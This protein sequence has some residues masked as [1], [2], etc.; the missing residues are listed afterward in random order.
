M[1]KKW[2]KEDEEKLIEL[3]GCNL[4]I[5]EIAEVLNRSKKAIY[6]RISLLGLSKKVDY[7]S[8][9]EIAKLE[10]M[11][12]CGKTPEI[13]SKELGRTVSAIHAK[14]SD[15]GLSKDRSWTKQ[16]DE[17]L[18]KY[19]ANNI[20][21][22]KIAELLNRTKSA[23][24]NRVRHLGIAKEASTKWS[25]EDVEQ[26]KNLYESGVSCEDISRK[27]NRS[28]GSIYT[29]ISISPFLSTRNKL[30]TNE[31]DNLLKEK[32]NLGLTN[33]EI[34]NLLNRTKS[35]ISRR[36]SL[37]GIARDKNKSNE[38]FVNDVKNKFPN[39][40]VLGDYVTSK[41]KVLVKYTDCGHTAEVEPNGLLSSNKNSHCR[42][43]FPKGT[44]K[45]QMEVEDFLK[46]MGIDILTG[47]REVLKGKELDIFVP[48]NLLGIEYNGEYWH[49]DSKKDHD[50]LLSKTILANNSCIDLVHIWEHEWQTKQNIV[51]SRL[52]GLLGQND[53]IFARNT[54]VKEIEWNLVKNFL[55]DCHIQGAGSPTN[56]NLALYLQ[57][58]LIALMTFG[59]PRFNSEYQFELVRYCSKLN[60]NVIGGAGKLLKHFIKLYKPNNIISY[61]DKRW[62]RG[63]LYK[64]LGFTKVSDTKPNY[65][66]FN[67]NKKISRYQAQKSKLEKLVPEYYDP[68]KTE[69]EM[70][71]D[72]GYYRCF[73]CG[74]TVWSLI[75]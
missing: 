22:A 47:D 52:A 5:E 46:G 31:D 60:T 11:L 6:H 56:I 70:M 14:T 7:W 34:A 58:E 33:D 40:E 2:T 73:D 64:K 41:T 9:S 1:S 59:K 61:S 53:R 69:F 27:L 51:K 15:L 20:S 17:D 21:Q 30:W 38:E 42:V 75:V 23:V 29:K 74:N 28:I 67:G 39:I 43:C 26:L 72:A 3:K 50:N 18:I 48:D 35:S 12:E 13:I 24:T 45:G 57:D 10:D 66:Y 54:I 71:T 37:L 8:D 19:I 65:F 63:N 25:S 49:S 68:S 4:S 44:S 62:G 32:L 36:L 55:E 16:E